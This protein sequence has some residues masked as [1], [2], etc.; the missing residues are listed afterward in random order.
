MVWAYE[1]TRHDTRAARARVS[2][3]IANRVV[4]K[5][6]PE[7][8]PHHI[9]YT[10]QLCTSLVA[11]SPKLINIHNLLLPKWFLVGAPCRSAPCAPSLKICV[12]SWRNV[13]NSYVC[14]RMCFIS[15]ERTNG[16]HFSNFW[17]YRADGE[18][19]KFMLVFHVTSRNRKVKLM[20]SLRSAAIDYDCRRDEYGIWYT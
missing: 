13:D 19:R 8:D 5:R 17:I 9:N 7:P 16:L 11:Q 3:M 20:F 6:L 10:R 18:I 1:D 14:A 15:A 12:R 2:R 4:C